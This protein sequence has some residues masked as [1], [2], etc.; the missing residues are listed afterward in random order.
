[1]TYKCSEC[2]AI[3]WLDERIN[4][5]ARSPKFSTCCA[6]GKVILPPL[7]ELPS[8]L[9]TF[10]TGT[11][12]CSCTFKQNIRMYNSALSFISIRAKIDQQITGTSGI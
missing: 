1:M 3:M 7:Q 2:K 5:S 9:N 11:D 6:N 4:K 8:P 10:L 12:P